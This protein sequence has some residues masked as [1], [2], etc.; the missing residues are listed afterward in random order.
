MS[1]LQDLAAWLTDPANWSGSA[2]IPNRLVEHVV[3]CVVAV[4]IATAVGVAAGLFIGHTGR[5]AFMT[6]SIA[7][8]G[9]AIPSY[10]LLIVFVSIL[11]LGFRNALAVL[12]LLAIPVVL[13]NTYAGMRDVDRDVVESGRAMGMSE[14]QLLRGVEVPIALPVIL[15]GTRTASVQVVATATLAA[16]VAGGGL[17]RF[18]VDGFAV[19]DQGRILGGA[20]LVALLALATE[21]LFTLAE[22]RLVSPGIGPSS[23]L[24]PTGGLGAGPGGTAPEAATQPA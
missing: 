16:L 10:A 4:L 11:G 17:G 12:I 1:A 2:G 19:R 3:L 21:R 14:W 9:R 15:A 7:N 24:G 8:L 22:R 5:G 13:T 6:V 20:I 23:S 18:I